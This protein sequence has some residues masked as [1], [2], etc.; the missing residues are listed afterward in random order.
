MRV[1]RPGVH[2]EKRH[3]RL[4]WGEIMLDMF[5]SSNSTIV[6]TYLMI[7]SFPLEVSR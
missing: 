1:E 3:A 7:L 4:R 6:C 2:E 5:D